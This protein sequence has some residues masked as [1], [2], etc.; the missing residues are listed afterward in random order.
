MLIVPHD[1]CRQA[2]AGFAGAHGVIEVVG[3][4]DIESC[5]LPLSLSGATGGH[6]ARRAGGVLGADAIVTAEMLLSAI[7][8]LVAARGDAPAGR[9]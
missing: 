5:A 6:G 2:Q 1:A 8:I 3:Q 4:R 9:R 7:V